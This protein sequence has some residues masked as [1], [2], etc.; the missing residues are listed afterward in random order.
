MLLNRIGRFQLI[1]G[2]V[3]NVEPFHKAD[4]S[5]DIVGGE[6]V[7][8]DVDRS[9]RNDAV[10]NHIAMA[11]PDVVARDEARKGFGRSKS[12][13]ISLRAGN[14][15]VV[16]DEHPAGRTIVD[17][18]RVPGEPIEHVANREHRSDRDWGQ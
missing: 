18:E 12:L 14:A 3:T 15:R 13:G 16:V 9:C 5:V 17:L 10:F 7:P 8:V 1:E 6:I 4:L 2:L 11:G